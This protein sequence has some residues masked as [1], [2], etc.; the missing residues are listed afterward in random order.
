[1]ARKIV[2]GDQEITIPT[3]NIGGL[4]ILLLVVGAWFVLSAF[5][6]VGPDEEGV[7][8]RFGKWVRTEPS[9]LHFKFPYP[10]EKVDLP[11]VTQ[12]QEISVGRI[13]KEAKMLTGDENI[14]LASVDTGVDYTHP[15]LIENIWVNQGEI[16][17]WIFEIEDIDINGDGQVDFNEFK[18]G[19]TTFSSLVNLN[20]TS[21]SVNLRSIFDV[22]D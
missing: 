1:M 2:V 18:E 15:D 22:I 4:A 7:V 13:L 8:R 17:E 12:V 21:N 16:L 20:L 11:K 6:V 19:I 5:Y 9:G 3:F 14:L 10:I